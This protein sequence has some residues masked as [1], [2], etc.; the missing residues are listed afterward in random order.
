MKYPS[1]LAEA[2]VLNVDYLLENVERGKAFNYFG[3]YTKENRPIIKQASKE[4][5]HRQI[6]HIR[7]MLL[8]LDREIAKAHKF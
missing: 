5:I 8:D 6:T 3:G 4:A 1:R 2:I 7:D